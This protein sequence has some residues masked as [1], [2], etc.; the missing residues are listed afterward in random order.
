[1]KPVSVLFCFALLLF[2]HACSP[3]GT[4]TAGPLFAEQQIKANEMAA[5]GNLR[6]IA[7]AQTTYQ[8]ANGQYA[9]DFTALTS[10]EPPFLTGDW[11]V[12]KN[13]YRF[14]LTGDGVTFEAN[15]DPDKPGETGNNHYYVDVNGAIHVEKDGPASAASE[16]LQ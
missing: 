5:I 8:S 1:M 14:T 3:A 4:P 10:G 9:A 15:A 11:T 12:V 6:T 16:V 7:G 2:L 13:G